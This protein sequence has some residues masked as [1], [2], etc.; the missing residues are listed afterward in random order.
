MLKIL[1]KDMNSLTAE[2]GAAKTNLKRSS[3]ARFRTD[4]MPCGRS[5]RLC[6]GKVKVGKHTHYEYVDAADAADW[7][8]SMC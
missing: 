5:K 2:A 8:R 7:L 6:I 4:E 1:H 3:I